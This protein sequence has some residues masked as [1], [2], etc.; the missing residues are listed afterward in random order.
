VELDAVLIDTL[1]IAVETTGSCRV[2]IRNSEIRSQ[3]VAISVTGMSQ[4][5][6]VDS[7]V[8]GRMGSVGVTCGTVRASGRPISV[9]SKSSSTTGEFWRRLRGQKPANCLRIP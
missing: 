1:G 9:R 7:V 5:E 3:G 2:V 6:I 8:V 4:V